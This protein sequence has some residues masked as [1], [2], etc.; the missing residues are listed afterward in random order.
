MSNT[1]R[2]SMTIHAILRTLSPMHIADPTGGRY[3]HAE[4]R[5][6]YGDQGIPCT[7]TQKLPLSST[8]TVKV[9]RNDGEVDVQRQDEVPI[10]AA[11]NLNGRLRRH[12]AKAIRSALKAKGQKVTLGTYNGMNCGAVTGSPDSEMLTFAEMSE[13]AEHPFL[14]LFGGGPRMAER[15]VRIHNGLPLHNSEIIRPLLTN[16]HHSRLEDQ[17]LDAAVRPTTVFTFRRNDDIKV[18]ADIVE[19]AETIADYEKQVIAYQSSL[20]AA[21]SEEQRAGVFT[22]SAHEVIIPLM[23]FHL[24]FELENVTEAQV[25][26]FLATLD[27]FAQKERIGGWSRNGYGRFMLTTVEAVEEDG[28]LHEKLFNDGRLDSS[29]N[30][31]KK[32]LEAWDAAKADLSAERL[33]HLLRP[34]VSKKDRDAAKEAKKASQAVA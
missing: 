26:L 16:L 18:L 17:W 19:Q 27:N 2:R 5:I 4:D 3:D 13:L 14:G 15:R 1:P 21:K 29:Q 30:V 12:A 11:N 20:L 32:A 6:V 7:M 9:K 28:T 8:R 23:N 10:I 34:A 31:V 22:F 25:G 24:T 33:E